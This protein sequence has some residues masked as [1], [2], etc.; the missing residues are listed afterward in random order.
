MS[1]KKLLTDWKQDIKKSWGLSKHPFIY[2]KNTGE[3]DENDFIEVRCVVC[4]KSKTKAIKLLL[5]EYKHGDFPCLNCRTPISD[6]DNLK[7]TRSNEDKLQDI[8]EGDAP[9]DEEDLENI[10]EEEEEEM[11]ESKHS[12]EE[13]EAN[14][15]TT[16]EEEEI[17]DDEDA[18]EEMPDEETSTEAFQLDEERVVDKSD[19]EFDEEEEFEEEESEVD[20]DVEDFVAEFNT[21]NKKILNYEPYED[22]VIFNDVATSEKDLQDLIEEDSL[23]VESIGVQ[24]R[25]CGRTI[26]LDIEEYAESESMTEFIE[27]NHIRKFRKTKY[28]DCE[29]IK[30]LTESEKFPGLYYN[31]DFRDNITTLIKEY[32]EDIKIKND[33]KY[34]SLQHETDKIVLVRLDEDGEI[35]SSKERSIKEIKKMLAPRESETEGE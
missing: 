8:A 15:E 20:V 29:C 23:E 2:P 14:E 9:E 7:K 30:S 31:A 35:V 17:V 5:T 18:E 34:N 19:L 33:E 22:F 1:V 32:D 3:M 24:C 10:I 21:V 25:L 4:G 13:E 6:Y 28:H 16:V 11:K 26:D 27:N 12:Q